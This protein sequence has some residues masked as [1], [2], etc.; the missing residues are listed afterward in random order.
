MNFTLNFFSK[1]PIALAKGLEKKSSACVGSSLGNASNGYMHSFIFGNT[2]LESL[3]INVITNYRTNP[4]TE[5]MN[6]FSLL[7]SGCPVA[8]AIKSFLR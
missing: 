7:Q 4:G 8:G 6:P 1:K 5:T 3:F 2:L